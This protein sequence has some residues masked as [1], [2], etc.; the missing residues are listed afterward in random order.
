[1]KKDTLRSMHHFDVTKQYDEKTRAK[2]QETLEKI[3]HAIFCQ[4]PDLHYTQG[5][6]DICSVFY[7]VCGERLGRQLSVALAK[8]HMRDAVRENLTVYQY[9]LK[10]LFP[11]IHLVDQQ[12]FEFIQN[13]QV[14]VI[15]G[16]LLSFSSQLS[17]H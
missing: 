10:L 3:L 13:S 2:E 7:I 12:V 11:L 5:F 9:I 1:V 16:I 6:H 17:E 8:R 15:I 14:F 4:N